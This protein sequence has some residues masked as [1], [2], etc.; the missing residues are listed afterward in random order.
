VGDRVAAALGVPLLVSCQGNSDLKI[1]GAKRSL[2]SVW[3]RI[4]RNADAVFPFAPWTEA[5][6]SALL[7]PR[8]KP[9]HLLPCPTPQDG[10]IRPA[11]AGPLV[12]TA[13]NF[14]DY[15]NKNAAALIEATVRA[16]A[17]VP[18]LRLEIFGG[19]DPEGFAQLA[20][21]AEAA[22]E[23]AVALAGPRPHD[24]MQELFHK[25]A[26][27]ALPS[28]RESYGMVF[29]EALLA[30]TPVLHSRGTAIDGYLEPG[31]ASLAV[32]PDDTDAI[33]EALV[34]LT[35][36]EERFKAQ[37][38]RLHDEGRLHRFKRAAIA[39]TYRD[40]LDALAPAAPPERR[41]S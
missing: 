32:D 29:A 22:P 35:R 3:Q 24:A 4:W 28:K 19:G 21:L 30:G 18:E 17:Q 5:G 27:F 7:G 9:T 38:A 6:L 26:A 23:G 37:L 2:R 16:R 8:D 39:Q 1:L 41:A 25:A 11:T 36:E 20:Q 13:F 33:A 12:R 40:A 14:A 15:A 10:V 34:R 31:M